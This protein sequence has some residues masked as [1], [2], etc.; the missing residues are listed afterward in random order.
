MAILAGQ[1]DEALGNVEPS[2][3]D[4]DNAPRAHEEVRAVLLDDRRLVGYGADPVLI[5]SYK[6]HVSIR[7]MKD[8]DVF[9]KLLDCPADADPQEL[10]DHVFAVL[11]KAF[12]KNDSGEPRAT[13]QDRSV[14]VD[15]PEYNLYVDAVVARPRKAHWEI[16][17]RAGGWEETN[18]ERLTTLTTKMNKAHGELYVP[19][20]KLVRQTR[21][22]ALSR[23]K[24]G[25]LYFEIAA[26]N[27]F[28]AGSVA[29]SSAA[30]YYTS[31]L[32]GIADQLD[33]AIGQGLGLDD[34]SMPDEKIRVRA[35][36]AQLATARRKFREAA[37]K[38]ADALAET[39]RCRAAKLFQELLGRNGDEELV[40]P[41]P[42]DCNPD[43][44]TKALAYLRPGDRR[45][46]AGDRRFG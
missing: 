38:A 18:P 2:K 43:G 1:F 6:R 32:A 29:G 39:N 16:P 36:P 14:Q 17:Q 9:C 10:L 13:R 46:P 5:G 28:A 37:G 45:V 23:Q 40:F 33:L 30:E 21:R 25:G 44:T 20:V 15:F 22:A 31:A 4:K 42:D 26:Y 19:T 8:V 41:L 34:P 27:A 3:D 12:G 7:R 24:P 11:D 35:T